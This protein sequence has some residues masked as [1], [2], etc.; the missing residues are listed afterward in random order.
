MSER[1]DHAALF[2]RPVPS[3]VGSR[4]LQALVQVC[5]Q[6]RERG[7][8]LATWPSCGGPWQPAEIELA[9]VPPTTLDS[10]SSIAWLARPRLV[11]SRH[12]LGPTDLRA[13]R[14]VPSH[15]ELRASL[16]TTHSTVTPSADLLIKN[17]SDFP[18]GPTRF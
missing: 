13:F 16:R 4:W 14:S 6:P 12:I 1:G 11:A 9:V 15:V 10:L 2:K 8:D 17:S 3:H 5:E 7:F 18:I